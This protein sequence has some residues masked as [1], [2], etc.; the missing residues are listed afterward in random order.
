M[1]REAAEASPRLLG[2]ELLDELLQRRQL[3][4]LD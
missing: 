4:P 2:G 3:A 1:R